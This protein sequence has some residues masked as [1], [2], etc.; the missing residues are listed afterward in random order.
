V[1][2]PEDPAAGFLRLIFESRLGSGICAREVDCASRKLRMRRLTLT[3]S[4]GS[5]YGDIV[6]SVNAPVRGR[7]Q[8]S[9]SI[10]DLARVILLADA[11]TSCIQSHGS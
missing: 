11:H 3:R 6:S 8:Q 5:D 9:G 1:E 2:K 7:E 4:F 10:L